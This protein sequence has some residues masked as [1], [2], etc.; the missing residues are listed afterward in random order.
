M[1]PKWAQRSYFGCSGVWGPDP[2]DV[3]HGT[4]QAKFFGRPQRARIS[5]HGTWYDYG[6]S[7]AQ[8]MVPMGLPV[9]HGTSTQMGTPLWYFLSM[10]SSQRGAYIG[11]LKPG[12]R[13]AETQRVN[14][15]QRSWIHDVGIR[16]V[17]FPN[18]NRHASKEL[19]AKVK[20]DACDA[21]AFQHQVQPKDRVEEAQVSEFIAAWK[22]EHVQEHAAKQN[23]QDADD[24]NDNDEEDEGS[25]TGLLRGY[26]KAVK[27]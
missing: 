14:E 22:E 15:H 25:C 11:G 7:C 21:K 26:T 2:C 16:D 19:Y 5:R 10:K 8:K 18:L 4:S 27:R 9:V 6:T 23:N 1:E 17:D 13:C 24:E 20:I 12:N 3:T